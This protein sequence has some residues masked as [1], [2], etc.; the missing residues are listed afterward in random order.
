MENS[1]RG[2]FVYS[3]A[4]LSE[5]TG[6]SRTD[7]MKLR[8][9][10]KRGKY[11][12]KS[13]KGK[14]GSIE[15]S[16]EAV[17]IVLKTFGIPDTDLTRVRLDY[18]QEIQCRT[19]GCTFSKET[20]R[21]DPWDKQGFCTEA[22][23]LNF[24]KTA[25]ST[26]HPK[27]ETPIEPAA[28]TALPDLKLLTVC[29]LPPNKRIVKARNGSEAVFDVIVPSNLVWSIGDPLRAKQ[30]EKH[31]GYLELVGKAPRWRSDRIYRHEFV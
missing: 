6:I 7:I 16:S 24:G 11:W 12:R 3:E 18:I 19:C 30:S 23:S 9:E 27:Q 1:M 28:L 21:P 26:C 5:V 20:V 2:K 4:R 15:L 14:G 17:D 10:M 25:E 31:H 8:K 13:K 22:C 29:A